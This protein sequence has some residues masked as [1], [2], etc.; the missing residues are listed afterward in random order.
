MPEEYKK[1][2]SSMDFVL[3]TAPNNRAIIGMLT[4]NETTTISISKMTKD[5]TFEEKLYELLLKDELEVVV[6]GCGMCE[7]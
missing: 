1:Y 6:E 3:G 4:Y 5:P 2:V 7:N